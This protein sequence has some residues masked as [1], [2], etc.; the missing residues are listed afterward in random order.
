MKGARAAAVAAVI[1]LVVGLT[2][3]S[4]QTAIETPAT[5]AA[6][7]STT[8]VVADGEAC[9]Y[10]TI[11]IAQSLV[12]AVAAVVP[13]QGDGSTCEFTDDGAPGNDVALAL[14]PDTT[15]DMVFAAFDEAKNAAE[16]AGTEASV[17]EVSDLGDIAFGSQA[18]G[19]T[20]TSISILWL[21]GTVAAALT[22]RSAPGVEVTFDDAVAAAKEIDAT[23]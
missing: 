6:S 17:S 3:C 1:A 9:T 11:E 10:L 23:M 8:A 19:K 5:Q 12:P 14:I 2:G 7:P 22:V 20:G 15:S 13:E 18:Q 21:R 4:S 16:A